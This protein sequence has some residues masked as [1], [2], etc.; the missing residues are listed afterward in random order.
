MNQAPAGAGTPASAESVAPSV[1]EGSVFEDVAPGAFLPAEETFRHDGA[2]VR[3]F[4]WEA[5]E[6]A[7]GPLVVLVHGFRGDHHGLAL[8]A[9]Q[10]RRRW[11]VLA[12][13]LPGYGVSE[14][15]RTRPHTAG[16][17]AEVVAA[18]IRRTGRPVLLVGHSF[19]SVVAARVAAEHPDEVLALALLN[20][21]CEPA[22]DSSARVPALAASAFYRA[23]ALL[24]GPLGNALVRSR[25]ITRI[26][27]EL[28]MKNRIPA[29]RRWINGQHAAYFGAFAT[30]RVVLESYDSSIRET[31]ADSAPE[32]RCPTLLVAGERDDLGSVAGQERLAGLFD[33]ARLEVIPQVGHL[34]HYETP[35]RAAMMVDGFFDELAEAGR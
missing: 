3:V 30:R 25:A 16:T 34:I 33:D 32:V 8:V 1:Q 5:E 24:P 17:Y 27:S 21:I 23:S 4:R 9:R 14:P 26:S 13:D 2:R 31:V 12:P 6:P 20:P 35:R 19:G 10:L 29:L 22:L 7:E 28:M 18:L 15:L 11:T